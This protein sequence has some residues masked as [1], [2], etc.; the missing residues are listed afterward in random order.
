M[1]YLSEEKKKVH[2]RNSE[3]AWEDLIVLE[4]LE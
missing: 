4:N 1:T 3:T 2:G